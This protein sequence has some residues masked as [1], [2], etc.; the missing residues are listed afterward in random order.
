MSDFQETS[1]IKML[2]K[3]GNL[4]KPTRGHQQSSNLIYIYNYPSKTMYSDKQ[5]LVGELVKNGGLYISIGLRVHL[6]E[7]SINCLALTTG[8]IDGIF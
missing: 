5:M 8:T 2:Q 7:Y 3:P 1:Q 6:L 4:R